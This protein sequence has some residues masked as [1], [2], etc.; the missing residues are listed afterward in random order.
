MGAPGAGKGT[1]AALVSQTLSVVH[2]AS[3]DLF[4]EVRQSDTEVG[5]LV[6]SYYDKGEL[7]PDDV[8]IRMILDRLSQPDCAKGVLLDGFPRTIQ[9]AE[10]LD[11]AL[12][13]EGKRVDTVVSIGVS[14]PE[15]LRRLSGRW[16]CPQCGASYHTVSA[17]SKQA[18]T[19]DRCGAA[20]YQRPDDTE[21]TAKNR[22]EVY[23]NQTTPLIDYYSRKGILQEMNG[24][25]TVEAVEQALLAVLQ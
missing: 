14:T 21:A 24:E 11:K 15:L 19:C 2:I 25:Q 5:R 7:V 20:L 4:R 8:T 10:A 6:K 22:L 3:G 16:L 23:N 12:E 18:G 13:G 9:Q 17:P 1:Q